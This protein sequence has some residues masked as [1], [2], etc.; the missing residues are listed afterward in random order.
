M[1]KKDFT[2]KGDA[3]ISDG[4][5]WKRIRPKYHKTFYYII[6]LIVVVEIMIL[7]IILI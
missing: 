1:I 4:K 3:W 7:C 6:A 2:D 5:K